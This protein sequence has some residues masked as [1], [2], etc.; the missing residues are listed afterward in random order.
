DA[1][2]EVCEILDACSA[3]PLHKALFAALIEGSTELDEPGHTQVGLFATQLALVRLIEA[4]GARP[5]VLIGHGVGEVAA[6]HV[7]GVCGLTDACR[8]AVARAGFPNGDPDD[9]GWIGTEVSFQPPKPTLISG[10]TGQS[11]GEDITT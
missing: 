4:N 2:D 1:F 10:H 6:A 8:L 9:C 3:L 5:D 7:A 11:V